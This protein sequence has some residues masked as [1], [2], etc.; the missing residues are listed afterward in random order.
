MEAVKYIELMYFKHLD[1][2]PHITFEYL[3]D[4]LV[5]FCTALP[6]RFGLNSIRD[7]KKMRRLFIKMNEAVIAHDDLILLDLC[8]PNDLGPFSD[9]ECL[10]LFKNNGYSKRTSEKFSALFNSDR[11]QSGPNLA[12]DS[13]LRN[14]NHI[15]AAADIYMEPLETNSITSVDAV[16][17]NQAHN[18][19]TR[20]ITAVEGDGTQIPL[21]A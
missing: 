7:L 21:S 8:F 12:I 9:H 17:E 3:K 14:Q 13:N 15:P 2:F 10:R 5:K 6:G 11:V 16:K 19:I 18:I 4:F 1:E 20:S